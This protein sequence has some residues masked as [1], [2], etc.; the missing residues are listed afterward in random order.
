LPKNLP[1]RLK[2]LGAK[3]ASLA[4]KT[5]SVEVYISPPEYIEERRKLY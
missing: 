1:N 5:N 2:N 4:P 3:I